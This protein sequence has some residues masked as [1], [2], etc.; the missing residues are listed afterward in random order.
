MR[1]IFLK[2]IPH[3]AKNI[4]DE[5]LSSGLLVLILGLTFPEARVW[6]FIV[7]LPVFIVYAVIK[8][9]LINIEQDSVIKMFKKYLTDPSGWEKRFEVNREYWVYKN[10]PLFQIET[11]EKLVE[12]FH[13]PWMKRYPD[14]EYNYSFKVYLKYMNTIVE[15]M[16][17]VAL[18]GIRYIVPIPERRVKKTRSFFYRSNSLKTKVANVIGTFY[19]Y[20]AFEEFASAHNLKFEKTSG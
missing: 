3:L 2:V 12:N 11:G 17:F 8:L 10:D 15:D 14:M 20:D 13:E 19:L 7:W 18:D 5:L 6:I 4:K 1:E 9:K 16:V